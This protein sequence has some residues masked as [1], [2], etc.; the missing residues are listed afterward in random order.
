MSLLMCCRS[1]VEAQVTI[2]ASLAV[3]RSTLTI[4]K[5][6]VPEK[7]ENNNEIFF[8]KKKKKET[9][10]HQHNINQNHK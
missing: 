1:R 9:I 6:W 7:S 3:Y 10:T 2:F 5:T 4:T 8:V